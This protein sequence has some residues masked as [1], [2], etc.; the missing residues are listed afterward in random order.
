MTKLEE[1]IKYNNELT[2]GINYHWELDVSKLKR[3]W[4]SDLI[5]EKF[6]IKKHGKYKTRQGYEVVIKEIKMFIDN[7]KEITYPVIGYYIEPTK[8]GSRK[9]HWAWSI[10]G[11]ANVFNDRFKDMDVIVLS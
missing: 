7:G 1:N 5:P 11:R 3:T 6:W 2:K 10:D 8:G 9:R 4:G